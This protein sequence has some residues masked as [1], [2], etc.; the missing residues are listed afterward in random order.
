[1][2]EQQRS[3]LALVIG[4]A[5][6]ALL[7]ELSSV[8]NVALVGIGGGAIGY[9]IWNSLPPTRRRGPPRYWRGRAYWD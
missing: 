7:A 6:A 3:W 2:S 1:M 5:I 9:A 8:R 4:V